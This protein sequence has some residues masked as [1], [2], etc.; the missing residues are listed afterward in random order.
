MLRIAII[1]DEPAAV[2]LLSSII[3]EYCDG[4]TIVDCASNVADGLVLLAKSDIDV[5]FVDIRLGSETIFELLA[6]IEY[7]RYKIV[8][9]TAYSDHALD[10]FKYEAIDYILKPY[11]PKQI[12]K[13]IEKL[14][15]SMPTFDQKD[16]G[17][18]FDA[19]Q[20]AKS[21]RISINTNE[22]ISFIDTNDIIHCTADGAY[23]K[24][25]SRHDGK[26]FVSKT[27]GEI[28]SQLNPAQFIRIHASH[29]IN[30]DHIK[31]FLKDDGGFVLMSDGT[32]IPVS[33]RKKQEFMERVR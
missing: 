2:Q 29:L 12:I 17:K 24:I 19:M 15:K 3:N 26:I 30:I 7:T 31:K 20:Q 16:L 32:L 14:K 11:S 9:T 25:A 28:E 27:L 10:A 4:V 1:E 8:F 6:Q 21:S 13:V 18:L 23:C 5:V 22:G 33:R